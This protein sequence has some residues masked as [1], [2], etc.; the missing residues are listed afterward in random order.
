MKKFLL[1][2]LTSSLFYTIIPQSLNGRF[3]SSIYTFERIDTAGLSNVQA[4]TFQMLA[5]N[6]GKDNVWLRSNLNLETDLASS[7]KSDARLRFYNLYVDVQSLWDIVSI[8][9]GRQPL[10]NSIA[11]GVFD[12]G[13]LAL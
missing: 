12:G 1:L 5:F 10:Y 7:L 9:L 11:G 8:K 2:L 3:S 13:T 4:R 6:F